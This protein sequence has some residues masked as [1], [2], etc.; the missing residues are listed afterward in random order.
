MGFTK[1][2]GFGQLA[3]VVATE[4]GSIKDNAVKQIFNEL[5]RPGVTPRDTGTLAHSW[6]YGPSTSYV[7]PEYR[8]YKSDPPKYY[9][10][11]HKKDWKTFYIWNNQPY[12]NQVND[13]PRYLEFVQQAVERGS[14]KAQS[15]AKY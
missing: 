12:L 3:Q 6:R 1:I 15:N 8:I 14:L 7:V 5:V 4:F 13:M 9:P 2:A 10:I 11:K